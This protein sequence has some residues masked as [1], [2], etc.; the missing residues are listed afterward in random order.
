M[1]KIYLL[2]FV[3]FCFIAAK[4]QINFDLDKFLET[5]KIYKKIVEENPDYLLKHNV[6]HLQIIEFTA[7]IKL[8]DN[9]YSFKYT[10]SDDFAELYK[11][12]YPEYLKKVGAN[13][14]ESLLDVLYGRFNKMLTDNGLFPT[15]KENIISNPTFIDNGL[16]NNEFEEYKGEEIL[17]PTSENN[18]LV[19]TSGMKSLPIGLDYYAKEEFDQDMAKVA[20]A[21][22]VDAALK[23][24][25]DI[26][27]D[28]KGTILL[29]RY[30]VL[31]DTW[32]SSFKKGNETVYK[33]KEL[34]TEL[35]KLKMPIKGV[36]NH[37][38]FDSLDN[39]LFNILNT[40]TEM[41]SYAISSHL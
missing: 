28:E 12:K 22:K 21:N 10:S 18:F 32:L 3:S 35:F 30:D 20:A 25:I 11:K 7:N 33:W 39:E 40:V 14:F 34:D 5:K 9:I 6:E 38:D 4:S 41:Y 13:Y 17:E 8:A 15:D 27:I 2:F 36:E 29:E 37:N 26:S 23:I 31:M 19:S 16:A 1:K 24:H